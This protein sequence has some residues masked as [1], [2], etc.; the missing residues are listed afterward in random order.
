MGFRRFR[1]VY[2]PEVGQC[3]KV[4]VQNAEQSSPVRAKQQTDGQG[5]DGFGSSSRPDKKEAELLAK[6]RLLPWPGFK[7]E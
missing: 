4:E 1:R 6:R 5:Q 2:S 3:P 7:G